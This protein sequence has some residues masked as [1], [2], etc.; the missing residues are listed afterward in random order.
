MELNR[1]QIQLIAKAIQDK[2]DR[3]N[4]GEDFY[5]NYSHYEKE[6]RFRIK[7]HGFDMEVRGI[8]V[9]VTVNGQ[10][11]HYMLSIWPW[12]DKEIKAIFKQVKYAIL[13]KQEL[14]F[15]DQIHK[16]FPDLMIQ[17]FEKDVMK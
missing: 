10:A 16:V 15:T 14:N 13:N 3:K 12:R 4:P 8:N 2:L 11:G 17:A 5:A 7:A 9:S 1:G 6:D